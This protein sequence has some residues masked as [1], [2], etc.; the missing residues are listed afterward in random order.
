MKSFVEAK[1]AERIKHI[2]R[3]QTDLEQEKQ[4]LLKGESKP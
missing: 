4:R 1:K 2:E 3:Q